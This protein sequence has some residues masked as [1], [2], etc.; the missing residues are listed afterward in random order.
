VANVNYFLR[1]KDYFVISTDPD[2]LDANAVFGFLEQAQWWTGLTR[3]SLDR[4]LRNSL[5]FSLL[6]DSRQI[7]FARVITDCV[8]YAYLCDVYIVEERR[9]QGLGSWL[10]RCVL[11]H[12]DLKHLKRVALI[13]HDA[14]TFYLAL[15][16]RFTLHSNCYMERLQEIASCC[17]SDVE[18]K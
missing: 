17:D 14:Q 2:L 18:V 12:P 10:I 9:K 16:F 1:E 3:E 4:A 5:C 8:T 6:E 7:G 15:D 11:E 13:T